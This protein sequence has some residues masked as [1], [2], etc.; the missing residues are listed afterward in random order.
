VH[1]HPMEVPDENL[2]ELRPTTDAV[3]RQ[4]IEPRLNM[5]P[6]TDGEVLDDEVVVVHLSSPTSEPEVIQPYSRVCLPSI[7]GDVGGRSE[8]R[9]EWRFLDATTEGLQAQGVRIGASVAFPIA[10]SATMLGGASSCSTSDSR[11]SAAFA[12]SRSTSALRQDCCHE[13][14]TLRAP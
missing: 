10:R 2:L 7:F 11:A 13:W 9:R 4:E 12:A 14:M 8:A 3:G 1:V 5:L 6:N